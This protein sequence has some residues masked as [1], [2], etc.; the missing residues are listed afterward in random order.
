MVL[1]GIGI[2]EATLDDLDPIAG[3]YNSLWCNWIRESGAWEDWALCGRFNIAMQFQRSPITL[4]AERNGAVIAAC[5][6]GIFDDG[7][8]RTNEAWRPMYESLLDQARKRAKTADEDLEG[9]LFGD[10]R[11]KA[12]ADRFA[13]TGNDY[14]QGQVNLIV[15]KPEWQGAGLGRR[16]IEAA[17]AR[18]REEGCTKFF[19]MSDNHSD[20]QFYDHLGM[21][22]IAEDHSQDTGDGF[23]VYIYGGEA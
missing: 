17:R 14:A 21:T 13:A 11:E 4:V 23:I 20:Y 15:I 9:S 22:R 18:M 16:L 5:L 3:I 10:S 8:P 2:R 6:V 1:E 19:L 12:T 7:A